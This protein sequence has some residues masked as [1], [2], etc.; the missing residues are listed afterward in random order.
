MA[1]R[2][3][4]VQF[5]IGF[6]PPTPPRNRGKPRGI[7]R[8]SQPGLVLS[9]HRGLTHVAQLW[10]DRTT[11]TT[12]VAGKAGDWVLN[13]RERDVLRPAPVSRILAELGLHESEK[14]LRRG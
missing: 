5:T 13:P 10:I 9:V 2:P 12:F 14:Q 4:K 3:V 11:A 7:S 1:T 8:L 6:T